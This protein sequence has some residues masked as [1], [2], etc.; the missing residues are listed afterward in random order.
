MLSFKPAFLLSCFTFIKGF[1][2]SSSFSAIRVV[3]PVYL[4]LMF[5]PAMLIP[6][7]GSSSLAFCMMYT[8]YKLNKQSDNIQLWCTSFPILNQ[9]VVPWPILI[10]ASWP[11]FRFLRRWVSHLF[12]ILQFF[13]IRTVKSFTI[14]KETYV[15]VFLELPCFLH[16]PSEVGNLTSDSSAFLNP[17][18]TSGC[19]QFMY[20]WSLAWR[21][22]SITLPACGMSTTVWWFEHSSTLPFFGIGMNSKVLWPLLSFPNLLTYWV[23]HFNSIT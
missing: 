23:Q 15:D 18:Y 14:I 20:C 8:A 16:N 19:S 22:L 6:A 10:V 21:T 2:S 11:T 3:S 5:F 12:K 1:F 7:C 4:T 9:P 13:V 17:A